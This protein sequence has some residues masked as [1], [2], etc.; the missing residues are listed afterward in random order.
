MIDSIYQGVYGSTAR[1][2]SLI[3]AGDFGKEVAWLIEDIN[4]K[5]PQWNLIGSVDDSKTIQDQVVDGRVIGS[6]MARQQEFYVVNA[7]A[8]P[9][10]NKS[11]ESP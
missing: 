1:R 10:V 11:N 6:R 3:G 5:S 2:I 7:I 8:D 9:V 4:R